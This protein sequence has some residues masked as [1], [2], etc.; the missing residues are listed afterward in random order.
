M[1]SDANH[2]SHAELGAETFLSATE[3]R[4][5]VARHRREEHDDELQQRQKAD[6]ARRR[7]IDQLS[8]RIEITEAMVADCMLRIREAAAAGKTELLILRF[9]SDMCADSGRAI[10]NDEPGWERTL[11][12]VP[13]QVVEFWE[14]QLRPRGFRC[15]ARILDYPDGMPGDVGMFY[16]WD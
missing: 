8:Q 15:R 12:G 4:A 1:T 10:N 7:L 16:A 9:P 2:N 14:Q 11:V 5:Y 3:L 6:A 13:Q